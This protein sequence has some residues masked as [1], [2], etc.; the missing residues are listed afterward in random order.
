MNLKPFCKHDGINRFEKK[1]KKY[2]G[3]MNDLGVHRIIRG[4]TLEVNSEG[5]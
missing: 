5:L 1:F 2:S 3:E 4:C